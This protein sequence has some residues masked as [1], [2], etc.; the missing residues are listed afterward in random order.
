MACCCSAQRDAGRQPRAGAAAAICRGLSRL[1]DEFET[2]AAED[3]QEVAL[4]RL[5]RRVEQI[6][7][8]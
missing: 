8:G 7:E 1:T 2:M 6:M 4:T 5:A 3:G